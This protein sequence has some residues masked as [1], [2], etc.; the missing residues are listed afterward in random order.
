MEKEVTYALFKIGA[1]L[2][3]CVSI[4]LGIPIH[5][6]HNLVLVK[7]ISLAAVHACLC[8]INS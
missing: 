6:F 8:V 1:I 5:C 4:R 2:V 7:N 3:S